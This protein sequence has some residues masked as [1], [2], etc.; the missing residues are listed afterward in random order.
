VAVALVATSLLLVGWRALAAAR[1]PKRDR[2]L[3]ARTSR[4]GNP[5]EFLSLLSGLVKR[6]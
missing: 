1:T 2:A 5:L 3:A 4:Q 6:W